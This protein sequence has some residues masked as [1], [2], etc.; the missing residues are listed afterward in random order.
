MNIYVGN[1][2]YRTSEEAL[3]QVFEEYGFVESVKIVKDR[4]SGRSKG[5]GFLEMPDDTEAQ[6]AIDGLH[7]T[8]FES[9]T[10]VVNQARPRS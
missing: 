9:R 3:R 6:R 1:L 7:Q 10:L 2:N 4:D 8:E 5:F